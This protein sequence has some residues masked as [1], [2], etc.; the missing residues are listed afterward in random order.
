MKEIFMALLL[1][2]KH[3][4]DITAANMYIGGK[5]SSFTVETKDGT[6][7]VNIAKEDKK[8]ED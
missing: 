1:D 5:F 2:L 3:F 8:N 4:G 7:T 6:Y